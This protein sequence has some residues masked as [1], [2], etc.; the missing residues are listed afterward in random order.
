MASKVLVEVFCPG[1]KGTGR[2]G[3]DISCG[4]FIGRFAKDAVPADPR[5]GDCRDLQESMGT[6][7]DDN[8]LAV[9][10]MLNN[11]DPEALK[12]MLEMFKRPE[13]VEEKGGRAA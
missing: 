2:S 3:E 8:N 11:A 10:R 6:A 13:P 9:A 1:T 4:Y 12:A 7:P 5:C